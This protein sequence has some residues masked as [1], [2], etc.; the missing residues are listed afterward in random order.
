MNA[1]ERL[2]VDELRREFRRTCPPPKAIKPGFQPVI[3]F[4]REDVKQG[5][6]V[7]WITEQS[8]LFSYKTLSYQNREI[9]LI[10]VLPWN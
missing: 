9:S 2:L 10:E 5:F 1:F 8:P 7:V 3:V 6:R 4:I